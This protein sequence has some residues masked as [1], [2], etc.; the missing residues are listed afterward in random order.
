MLSAAANQRQRKAKMWE[1]TAEDNIAESAFPGF[2]WKGGEQWTLLN[3]KLQH[4]TILNR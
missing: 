4:S 3:V 2:G 1:V